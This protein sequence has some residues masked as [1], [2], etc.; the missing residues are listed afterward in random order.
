MPH[1][2]TVPDVLQPDVFDGMALIAVEAFREAREDVRQ[3]E[4]DSRDANAL[5]HELQC[6]VARL[7][8]EAN[9]LFV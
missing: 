5:I 1:H 6:E 9:I 4:S 8:R 2:H 7:K 3:L